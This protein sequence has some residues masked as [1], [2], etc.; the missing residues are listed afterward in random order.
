[1]SLERRWSF[2]KRVNGANISRKSSRVNTFIPDDQGFC[3]I[4][5]E[6]GMRK[7]GVEMLTHAFETPRAVEPEPTY[8]LRADVS[9]K[10]VDGGRVGV[11]G[12]VG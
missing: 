3:F 2:D 9:F 6:W 4:L 12:D 7:G 5:G 11:N 8:R 10:E 1:M